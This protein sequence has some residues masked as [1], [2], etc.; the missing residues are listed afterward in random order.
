MIRVT[1]QIIR[2]TAVLSILVVAYGCGSDSKPSP[3]TPDSAAQPL[4]KGQDSLV[5]ELAGNDQTTVLDLLKAD[6]DVDYRSTAV[7]A[8][9][10][11][12]DEA[13]SGAEYFWMYSVNDSFPTTACD[14]Y[15]TSD[16]D[17]VVWHFRKMGR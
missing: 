4:T 14:K 1:S 12:V 11:Q 9:V 13:E 16:G 6:H 2:I 10:T 15:V 17:R 8:F 7:G 3:K 5:I